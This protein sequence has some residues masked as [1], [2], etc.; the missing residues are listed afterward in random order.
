MLV[1]RR[2][3]SGRVARWDQIDLSN[4]ER[5]RLTCSIDELEDE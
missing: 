5:P 3:I 2:A 1:G 4:A